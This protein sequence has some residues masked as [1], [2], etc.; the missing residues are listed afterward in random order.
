MYVQLDLMS[1]SWDLFQKFAHF[2]CFSQKD[3]CLFA[4]NHF[5][6]SKF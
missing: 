4:V 3:S 2:L 1:F 6:F 5:L